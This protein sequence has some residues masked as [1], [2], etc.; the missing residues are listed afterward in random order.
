MCRNWCCYSIF[1]KTWTKV[2][3]IQ[4]RTICLLICR[5][6]IFFDKT[7][8][9][10]LFITK[11]CLVIRRQL[12]N[13]AYKEKRVLLTRDVKLLKYQYVIGNQVYKIKSLLKN[14]QL[15]EVRW[16]QFLNCILTF[17]SLLFNLDI[18]C[19]T[20]RDI[21][22]MLDLSLVNRRFFFDLVANLLF[23]LWLGN[24]CTRTNSCARTHM[25]G[26]NSC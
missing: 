1:E 11:F 7:K 8:K 19:Y 16:V 12:L 10:F 4:A 5:L 3:T 25:Q 2:C 13:Q 14:D 23:K 6:T 24:Y 17:I 22:E 21:K 9:C 18:L 20:W 15:V 26:L